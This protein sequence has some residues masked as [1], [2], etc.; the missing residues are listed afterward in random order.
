MLQDALKTGS[1]D[2]LP[3][4]STEEESASSSQSSFIDH[5]STEGK[6]KQSQFWA[7]RLIIMVQEGFWNCLPVIYI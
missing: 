5:V 2:S 7:F 3:G 1:Q 6:V 4:K